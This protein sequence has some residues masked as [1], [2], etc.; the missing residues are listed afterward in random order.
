MTRLLLADVLPLEDPAAFAKLYREASSERRRTADSFRFGKDRRLSL[1]AA[2]LLDKGLAA[3][4]LRERDMAYGRSANGKPFFL[5]A[6]EIHFNVSHSGTKVAVAFSDREVGCDIEEVVS[7]QLSAQSAEQE[8]A[9]CLE[10]AGRF[11]SS[12]EYLAIKAA[13]SPSERICMF[14][15]CWTLKESYMKATGLGM[16][17]APD[18]FSVAGLSGG[19]FDTAGPTLGASFSGGQLRPA[20]LP[21]SAGPALSAGLSGGQLR[22]TGLPGSAG[23][24]L[25]AGLSGGQPSKTALAS[26]EGFVLRTIDSFPGYACALCHKPEAGDPRVEIIELL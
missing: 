3:F 25:S 10:M 7:A 12:E 17:L 2:A 22:P 9:E 19:R 15:R 24:A 13:E 14:Y 21:G 6:P 23:P 16:A 26:D 1:G 20:A 11:F 8:A 4:G 5:N 18:T